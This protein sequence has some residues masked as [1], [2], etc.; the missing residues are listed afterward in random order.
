MHITTTHAPNGELE[1]ITIRTGRRS[2]HYTAA[3]LVERLA[4]ADRRSRPVRA[5][6][7]SVRRDMHDILAR[8]AIVFGIDQARII[9]PS[10]ERRFTRIRYAVVAVA[11]QDGHTLKAI[12][13]ALGGRATSVI[14]A[15]EKRAENLLAEDARFARQVTEMLR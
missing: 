2:R 1:S 3:Q 11:R 13:A 7:T 12:A 4:I 8:A 14:C 15:A 6:A 9:G 5:G 10:R